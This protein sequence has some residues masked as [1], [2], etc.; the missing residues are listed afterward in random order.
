MYT[1]NEMAKLLSSSEAKAVVTV[2]SKFQV[3]AESIN[4]I[5]SI[6]YPMIV[7][8][9]GISPSPTGTINFMDLVAE[10]VTEFKKTGKKTETNAAIDTVIL[11]FSSGTTGIPKGVELTH[12]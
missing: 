11:P 4:G 2:S 12:R 5:D 1:P 6:Q 7:F 9:D 8:D 3:V 10:D